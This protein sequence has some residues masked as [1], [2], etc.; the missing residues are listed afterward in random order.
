M[1]TR[2]RKKKQSKYV[3]TPKA[4][5]ALLRASPIKR[6][7]VIRLLLAEG[8]TKEEVMAELVTLGLPLPSK[9]A[10]HDAS[11]YVPLGTA[12]GPAPHGDIAHNALWGIVTA[13][14]DAVQRVSFALPRTLREAI[15]LGK[16]AL[17]RLEHK[18]E[19]IRQR[20]AAIREKNS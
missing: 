13:Y 7:A 3:R 2:K 4:D 20:Q 14:D 9:Q 5:T 16:D 6:A 19:K 8:K 18:Q 1:A 17:N 15:F 10:W 12:R 11:T